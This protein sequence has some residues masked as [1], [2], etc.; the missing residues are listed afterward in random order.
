[1]GN[2]GAGNRCIFLDLFQ[3]CTHNW[4]TVHPTENVL[5]SL[6]NGVQTI[7]IGSGV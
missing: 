1:M 3:F 4:K 2:N 7:E 5:L 6:N